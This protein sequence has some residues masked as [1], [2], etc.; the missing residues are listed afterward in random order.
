MVKASHEGWQDWFRSPADFQNIRE[1]LARRGFSEA[2][3]AKI[4][5]GNWVR[6][7]GEA[8]QPA[9]SVGTVS[10]AAAQ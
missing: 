6:L 7:F 3:A 1:G 9:A 5:G 8:F 2:E 10:S 4:L